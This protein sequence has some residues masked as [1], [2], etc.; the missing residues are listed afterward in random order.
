MNETIKST[1]A[2]STQAKSTQA[3]STQAKSTQA[4][5]T[6]AARR[7]GRQWSGADVSRLVVMAERQMSVDRI[8]RKLGRTPAAVRTEAAKRR[9]RLAPTEKHLYGGTSSARARHAT[10]RTKTDRTNGRASDRTIARKPSSDKH[11]LMGET[12]F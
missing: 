10:E 5:S 11:A 3:K 4:K 9:L 7:S 12:L 8:A 1:Q 6:Q 2:K